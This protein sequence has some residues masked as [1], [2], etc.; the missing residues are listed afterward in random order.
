MAGNSL[1][2]IDAAS[3]MDSRREIAL[4]YLKLAQKDLD[5]AKNARIEYVKLARQ[6]GVTYQLIGDALGVSDTAVRGLVARSA[7]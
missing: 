2:K 1:S 6:Y 3:E 5:R 7:S 4:Q